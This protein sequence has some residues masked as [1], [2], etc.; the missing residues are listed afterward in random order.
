MM[1][2]DCMSDLHGELPILEGGDLLIIAGDCT[3]NDTIPAWN[4]FFNWVDKQ[5]YRKKI[6][7]AGNHDN[8]CKSWA[9]TG[10]FNDNEYEVM[11]PDEKRT[12]EYLCDSGT[13][14]EGL[15]I[16]G[17][18]WSL[19]FPGINPH[20]TAFTGTEEDLKA[21][22]ELIPDDIDILI[23]HTPPKGVLDWNVHGKQCGSE[24][25]F[26]ITRNLKNLKLFV[27]GH[28]HEAYSMI[29]TNQ[30]LEGFPKILA[31]SLPIIVNASIMN[32]DYEPV[33]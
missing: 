15:K 18:P 20:C 30:I 1:K 11:Y 4:N 21:K 32:E 24:S 14:F 12:I 5:N 10:N 6:M 2:I 23:T 33:N 16:H 26:K 13:E 31:S 28:I 17:S 3:S 7:I 8:F 25:L 27:F 29:N 19:T 22:F 9:V